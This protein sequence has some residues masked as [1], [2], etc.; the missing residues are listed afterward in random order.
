MCHRTAQREDYHNGSGCQA[1]HH[2]E[3]FGWP[4]PGTYL[5]ALSFLFLSR[6]EGEK[7]TLGVR[8]EAGGVRTNYHHRFDLGEYKLISCHLQLS[9]LPLGAI[10]IHFFQ[11]VSRDPYNPHVFKGEIT[12][13]LPVAAR[14]PEY[15]QS[16]IWSNPCRIPPACCPRD[17][18][19]PQKYLHGDSDQPTF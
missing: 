13:S 6:E 18:K 17:K 11:C 8:V 16:N 3:N 14:E 15:T 12:K 19:H 10:Q 1:A 4:C 5:T 7:K 2:S 9:D